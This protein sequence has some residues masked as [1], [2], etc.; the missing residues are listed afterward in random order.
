MVW[1]IYSWDYETFGSF[2]GCRKACEPIHIQK[3][4]DDQKVVVV[5][6]SLKE[7]K[8]AK[9]IYEVYSLGGKSLFK[10]TSRLNVLANGLTECFVQDKPVAVSGVY[11]EDVYKRQPMN[12]LCIFLICITMQVSLGRHRNVFVSC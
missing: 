4:L 6:T 1:Q 8:G 12:L 3:N 9:V 10:R 2:Y 7:I 11:M 5:N